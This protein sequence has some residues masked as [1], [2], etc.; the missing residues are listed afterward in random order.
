M[1]FAELLLK[2]FILFYDIS[3]IIN[4]NLHKKIPKYR[5]SNIKLILR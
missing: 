5:K 2:I 3:C 1:E 4:Q